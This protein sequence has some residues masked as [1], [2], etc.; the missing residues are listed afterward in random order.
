MQISLAMRMASAAI[1]LAL[2]LVNLDKSARGGQS[3]RAAGA[4]GA[5]AVVR[6]DHVAIAGKQ[7]GGFRVGDDQQRVQVAQRAVRAP[8]LGELDGGARQ[9]AVK[10]LQLVFEAPEERER[11]GGAAGESRDNFVVVE[12][13]R[14]LALCLITPSPS[15]DLAIGGEDDFIVFA[16]AQNRGAVH[17]FAFVRYWHPTII[18]RCRGNGPLRRGTAEIRTKAPPRHRHSRILCEGSRWIEAGV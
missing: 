1:S 12:A 18:P 8:F 17:L 4:D 14:L 6:L 9:I 16:D 5:D 15:G 13:A 3:V 10:F 11:V 7:E 2:S